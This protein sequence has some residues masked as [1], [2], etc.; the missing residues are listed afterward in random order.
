MK[1]NERENVMNETL[2]NRINIAN[3]VFNLI[4]NIGGFFSGIFSLI[5]IVIGLKD[6]KQFLTVEL[7]VPTVIIDFIVSKR[8][9]AFLAFCFFLVLFLFAFIRRAIK[10]SM[11]KINER[12][13][14]LKDL[15]EKLIHNIRNNIAEM[16]AILPM[17]IKECEE[18]GDLDELYNS[19]LNLLQSNLQIYA[20]FL[21]T[22]I[23]DYRNQ[24]VSACIKTFVS[25]N[26]QSGNT[27][28]YRKEMLTTIARSKNTD[29]ARI[30]EKPTSVEANTDFYDLCNGRILFFGKTNLRKLY[31]Q[32]LYK[33][34]T[35]F[36]W[37]YYNSTLVVSIRYCE[38]KKE[39]YDLDIRIDTI[40]FLCIDC[41]DIIPEWE[42]ADSYELQFM[43]VIADSLYTYL[44]IFYNFFDNVG[45]YSEKERNQNG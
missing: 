15:H 6:V 34:D 41:K 19:E 14:L 36:F 25:K 32:K 2:I 35:P 37:K 44:R 4:K 9:V 30:K 3:S 28:D 40:G 29:K 45:Y 43:A 11:D 1:I 42:E 20:D 38:K 33:N 12:T 27:V 31:N 8:R 7:N 21:S 10:V 23:S 5:S 39:E 24:K 18:N 26:G 22:R 16:Q 13:F 17:K